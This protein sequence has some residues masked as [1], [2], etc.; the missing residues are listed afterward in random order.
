MEADTVNTNN[1]RFSEGHVYRVNRI[2]EIQKHLETERDKRDA[3]IMKYHRVVL[4]INTA[5][6]VLMVVSMSLGVAGIG[7][8]STVVATPIA[9]GMEIT[10]LLIG[11]GI[12]MGNQF[13][14]KFKCKVDKHAKI[15]LLA[16]VKLGLINDLF[17]RALNDDVISDDEYS[18]V[19][20]EY[21]DFNIK[22]EALRSDDSTATD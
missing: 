5:T 14:K 1:N 7:V 2:L 3:L 21:E 18:L 17:S 11:A 19:L 20:A 16:D 13:N 22:R 15:K 8:L 10:T 9:I 12:L 4:A 6:D